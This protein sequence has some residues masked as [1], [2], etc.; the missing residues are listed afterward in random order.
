MY[1]L[2]LTGNIKTNL[3]IPAEGIRDLLKHSAHELG[4]C[5]IV[6]T[7]NKQL[8]AEADEVIEI[9]GGFIRHIDA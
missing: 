7:H 9:S 4:K 8:A 5:V 3:I 6:V 1:R 2:P